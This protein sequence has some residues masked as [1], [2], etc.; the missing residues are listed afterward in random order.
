MVLLTF[1]LVIRRNQKAKEMPPRCIKSIDYPGIR[2]LPK[3]N[4]EIGKLEDT[5]GQQTIG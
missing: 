4:K 2:S 1:G 5:L 3:K